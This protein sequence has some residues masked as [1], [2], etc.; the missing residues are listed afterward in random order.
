[1]IQATDLTV[2]GR[3]SLTLEELLDSE[4][5]VEIE[6]IGWAQ[7]N[8]IDLELW[9]EFGGIEQHMLDTNAW[10]HLS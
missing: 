10:K 1:M 3:I 8:W 7:R 4:E 5:S 9:E 2:I 6:G